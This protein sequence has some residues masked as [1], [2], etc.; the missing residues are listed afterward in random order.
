MRSVVKKIVCSD[1]IIALKL[2]AEPVIILIMQV[3]MPTSEYEDD[4]VESLYD[5]I[6]E[7]LEEDG[8]GIQTKSY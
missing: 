4:E 3:Y 8:K 1:R 5:T 6:E 7:I 2:K